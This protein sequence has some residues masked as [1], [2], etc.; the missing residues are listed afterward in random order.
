MGNGGEGR[1][2]GT[3]TQRKTSIKTKKRMAGGKKEG[4]KGGRAADKK[5]DGDEKYVQSGKHFY[6]RVACAHV[7][8][9]IVSFSVTCARKW[10]SVSGTAQSSSAD[11]RERKSR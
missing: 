3:V 9:Y 1:T 10:T 2:S 7:L 8:R 4:D 11:L 5:Y 6:R